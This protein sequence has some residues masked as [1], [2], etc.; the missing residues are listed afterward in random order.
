MSLLDSVDYDLVD[1][2]VASRVGG[3]RRWRAAVM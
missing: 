2:Y 1:V 3:F